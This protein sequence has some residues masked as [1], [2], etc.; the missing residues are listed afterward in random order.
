MARPESCCRSGFSRRQQGSGRR[1]RAGSDRR[2]QDSDHAISPL[3]LT[4]RSSEVPPPNT[5]RI[6][7]ELSAASLTAS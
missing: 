1:V 6:A 3:V 5:R 7:A 2:V 4:R